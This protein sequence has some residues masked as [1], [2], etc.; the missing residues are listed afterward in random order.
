MRCSCGGELERRDQ[1]WVCAAC[2]RSWPEPPPELAQA[3]DGSLLE[4]TG[5]LPFPLALV[6][7]EYASE[8]H[9]F[10]RLHRM[11]DAAEVLTR[12]A[13]LVLLADVYRLEGDFPAPLRG[14]LA[15]RFERPSF[16]IWKELVNWGAQSLAT[17]A[18]PIAPSLPGYVQEVLLP[19]LGKSDAERRRTDLIALRNY[20]VHAG[21][22]PTEDAEN[23]L[24]SHDERFQGLWQP[25][26]DEALQDCTLVGLTQDRRTLDLT[27]LPPKG[28]FHGFEGSLEEG[29]LPPGSAALVREGGT[30]GVLELFPLHVF[31]EVLQEGL[32]SEDTGG[33][34]SSR[35]VPQ[36]YFR[37]GNDGRA[38]YTALGGSVSFGRPGGRVQEAFQDRFPLA[39][40]RAARHVKAAAAE[41]AFD[42]FLVVADDAPDREPEGSVVDLYHVA[43]E[44]VRELAAEAHAVQAWLV[45]D[46]AGGASSVYGDRQMLLQAVLGSLRA[47]I[48]LTRPEDRVVARLRCVAEP[49]G[50]SRVELSVMLEARSE[51]SPGSITAADFTDL[52]L[53]AAHRICEHH[54]GTFTV[55]E[56]RPGVIWRLPAAPAEKGPLSAAGRANRALPRQAAGPN[57]AALGSVT[58]SLVDPL[59]NQG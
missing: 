44:A 22:I 9:P 26:A 18:E 29:H 21:R 8:T 40:W 39:E 3:E 4:L 51:R 30:N 47:I 41:Y 24:E 50:P 53:D 28:K 10:V 17:T 27:G 23:L 52:S 15:D 16:G 56:G 6:L 14:M 32:G 42:D 58:I 36:L 48:K 33:E 31:G 55:M 49:D 19:A 54:H 46:A 5:R 2:D 38:E 57:G 37:M 59:E 1:G 11:V 7:S 20:A 34:V 13:S 35:P 45:L 25:L 43:R 12:F